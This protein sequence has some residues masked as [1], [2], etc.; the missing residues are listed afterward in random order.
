MQATESLQLPE[1][2]GKRVDPTYSKVLQQRLKELLNS[3]NDSFPGSQP[4]SFESK[5][6]TDIEREDYFVCEKS[7]GVRY[8][9]FFLHSPKGPASFLFDRNKHWYYVPNLLFP[10]RGRE[11]EFLK[12]TIMDGEIVLDIDAHKCTYTAGQMLQQDIIQ[13][14]NAR[15][16]QID[17]TKSPPFTI[18]LKKM[19]RSYGLHLVFEQIP[20][21]KHKSDGIVFT[22][23]KYPYTPGTCE[24]LL[25]WK[26]PELNTVD[27]RIAA[28]WSK[29]HKP[30]YS[31]EVL[32]NGVTY[33]FYDHFQPEPSL[34]TQW[35]NQLPDGRIAEFRYDPQCEVTIIEQGYAPTV[36]KGGWRFVR[37][38]DDKSTANDEQVVK[39]IL[40]SIHD[41]V[42]KEQLLSCMDR[43]RAAWKAREK[44]LPMP[45]SLP[46]KSP[47][48]LTLS[49]QITP[50]AS[51]TNTPTSS[52]ALQSPSLASTS[53]GYFR[54][55]HDESGRRNSISDESPKTT[56]KRK[57]SV[58]SV[59]TPLK[60]SMMEAN[61]PAER[62]RLKSLVEEEPEQPPAPPPSASISSAP[63]TATSLPSVPVN[64]KDETSETKRPQKSQKLSPKQRLPKRLKLEETSRSRK[65][66][67]VD[68]KGPPDLQLPPSSLAKISKI[69][70]ATSFHP[71]RTLSAPA[72]AARPEPAPTSE[73]SKLE[74][75]DN[76][77]SK[78]IPQLQKET[79]MHPSK[80]AKLS[81]SIHNLLTT[82]VEPTSTKRPYDFS[83][84]LQQQPRQS[85]PTQQ[86]QQ[87]QQQ[88]L[89]QQIHHHQQLQQMQ[90]QQQQHPQPV[91]FINFH[92]EGRQ[93]PQ[94]MNK[95][96]VLII[97]SESN[98][99]S[100]TAAQQQQQQ[101]QQQQ[102][103]PQY[104]QQRIWKNSNNNS[105][106]NVKYENQT[107][108]PHIPPPPQDSYAPFNVVSTPYHLPPQNQQQYHPS[109]YGQYQPP[110]PQPQ[111]PPLPPQ[112]SMYGY[113][114]NEQ[115]VAHS[116]QQQQYQQ[117]QQQQQQQTQNTVRP[118]SSSPISPPRRKNSQKA[119]LDFI[120]N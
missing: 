77:R 79:A 2:I 102:H 21:L 50:S 73:S 15:M 71:E 107:P 113:R 28:R 37:F 32:S 72:V 44:G 68:E 88:P 94:Q 48:N 89:Q 103:H 61:E 76:R 58:A 98:S 116:Y 60:E 26:P 91:Q 42:T 85:P 108:P 90:Q 119:K 14:Y 74:Y 27:F 97:R 55:S 8:L 80:K 92:A 6:L 81:S 7:D 86:Q 12:D 16:R 104:Q 18:E 33:K 83:N 10:V 34:A 49:T 118:S 36:R 65:T 112:T 4:V 93:S 82:S 38:R 114:R 30:I 45:P 109:Y 63:V 110:P 66:S 13:P 115:Q 52:T 17:P 23:V 96:H 64:A 51:A 62:K 105:S 111:T 106:N 22:P 70:A 46:S 117:Q 101:Q 57:S 3:Q 31:I 41:G 100:P 40:L 53:G 43:V 5:H 47:G 19:E 1:S 59:T 29:E 35:K 75:D 20:K 25:K 69:P 87:Q 99:Q 9:L 54:E 120:L 78:S 24:K 84:I 95:N 67:L 39:K 11:N 56:M